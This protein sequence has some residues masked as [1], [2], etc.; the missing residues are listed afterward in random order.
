MVN[1]LYKMQMQSKLNENEYNYSDEMK[2]T[3][4][5]PY[6]YK[7]YHNAF[8]APTNVL[9]QFKMKSG[10]LTTKK[11]VLKKKKAVEPQ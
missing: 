7:Y 6:A 10:Y 2:H 8:Q 4:Q 1:N 3:F 11:I 9:G 5:N